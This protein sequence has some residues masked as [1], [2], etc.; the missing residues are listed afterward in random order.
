MKEEAIDGKYNYFGKLAK[1]FLESNYIAYIDG[2]KLCNLTKDDFY[3]Y[4][5]H[6]NSSGYAKIRNLMEIKLKEYTNK[7]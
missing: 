1:N 3:K 6:P 2:L 5:G 4:D 7:E